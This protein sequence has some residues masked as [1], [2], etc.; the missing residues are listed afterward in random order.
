MIGLSPPNVRSLAIGE[1]AA[2]TA[3]LREDVGANAFLLGWVESQGATSSEAYTLLGI[4]NSEGALRAAALLGRIGVLCTSHGTRDDGRE[5]A[6]QARGRGVRL[7]T[8]LGPTSVI[9]GVLESI[10]LPEDAAVLAQ[11][12]YVLTSLEEPRPTE[13][14]LRRAQ[15]VD[16]DAIFDAS[17]KM[18]TEEVGR[19]VPAAR[20]EKLRSS[21]E[22][23]ISGGQVWCLYD[24]F[25]GELVF[26]AAVGASSELV[27]QLEGVWVPLERRRGG[28]ARRCVGELCARLLR[29]HACV[30]LYVGL[31]NAP[32]RSLYAK[33]GFRSGTPFTSALIE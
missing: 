33:L 22:N 9:D 28:I 4:W 11:R 32:A 16:T 23:K 29:R 13:R 25:S 31:D 8:A 15:A 12:V 26:K 14:G 5:W 7:N 18:H 19:P 20:Y 2:L 24:D 3:F 21:I 30:S 17:L 27:A 10:D 1:R 6:R